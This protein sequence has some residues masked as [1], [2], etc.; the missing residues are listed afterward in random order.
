MESGRRSKLV[1]EIQIEEAGRNPEQA[2]A[3]FDDALVIGE[4]FKQR[5]P[6]VLQPRKLGPGDPAR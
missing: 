4:F 1:A 3:S 6:S 5:R 2:H